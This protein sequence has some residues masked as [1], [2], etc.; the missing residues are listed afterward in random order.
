[1]CR[2]KSFYA[3]KSGTLSHI[4]IRIQTLA[5]MYGFVWHNTCA[6]NIIRA[7]MYWQTFTFFRRSIVL[8]CKICKF[9]YVRQ[10]AIGEYAYVCMHNNII[11]TRFHPLPLPKGIPNIAIL[12][13]FI[14]LLLD[15]SNFLVKIGENIHFLCEQ[16]QTVV[17]AMLWITFT[18]CKFIV[19]DKR[20]LL[21]L[22]ACEMEGCKVFH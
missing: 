3:R 14:H 5:L 15:Y 19:I 1:M 10:F 18:V 7:H 17:C 2:F 21:K 22:F 13:V 9:V 20:D 16:T 6:N 11:H 8:F 4:E 12:F